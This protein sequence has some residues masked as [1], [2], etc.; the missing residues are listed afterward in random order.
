MSM[1]GLAVEVMSRVRM[2]EPGALITTGVEAP[3]GAEIGIRL[4]S[5]PEADQ[6]NQQQTQCDPYPHTAT[7][8][9]IQENCHTNGVAPTWLLRSISNRDLRSIWPNF[10]FSYLGVKCESFMPIACQ[11]KVAHGPQFCTP[12]TVLSMPLVRFLLPPGCP[13]GRSAFSPMSGS[14]I[15]HFSI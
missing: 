11:H 3:L 4:S 2:Y 1:T 14:S 5:A 7:A 10:F 15:S 6:Q 8:S 12:L 9:S 13:S